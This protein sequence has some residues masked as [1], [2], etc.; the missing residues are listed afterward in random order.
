MGCDFEGCT[1]GETGV[2]ALERDPKT[3]EHE[4]GNKAG[5]AEAA[6]AS[7]NQRDASPIG[8]P[9]LESPE[10]MSAFRSSRTLGPDAISAMMASRYVNVVGILGDPESGKTACL[11]S[12]Y[13]LVS[14]AAFA[15][16]K[17][18]DSRS[19]TAFEEI[20]RGAREWATGNPP[21]QM[22]V[23]TELSDD[24]RPGFLHLRLVRE[25]DGRRIDFALPDLPGEW[26]TELVGVAK[27]DRLEFLKAAEALWI[28][29]DGRALEDKE[30]RQGLIARLG[31]L[32]GRLETMFSGT[33]P[34]MMLVIT[35]RD[36]MEPSAAVRTGLAKELA[37]RSLEAEIMPVAPF[38]INDNVATAGFGMDALLSATA[39]AA[40]S[41]PEFW[42]PSAPTEG[43]RSYISYRKD[44]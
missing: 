24:R 17:F 20:A 36:S 4:T 30:R 33:I 23:H 26:T 39:N 11:A 19:L 22:T 6:D 16:W 27:S 7:V 10:T 31:Q 2:C 29:L 8:A 44:R 1:V 32:A 35:H 28:V 21:E 3:C 13:L 42:S 5:A 18:A 40:P 25:A 41:L 43:T 12:L 9:V 15:G 38:S 34:K 37:K 14:N